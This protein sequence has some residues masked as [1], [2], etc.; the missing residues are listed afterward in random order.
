[1][2]HSRARGLLAASRT[3]LGSRHV[4]RALAWAC[5]CAGALGLAGA[6]GGQAQTQADTADAAASARVEGEYGLRVDNPGDS[7]IVYWLTPGPRAD[8]LVVRRGALRQRYATPAAVTHRV[9]FLAPDPAPLSLQYA[10]TSTTIWPGQPPRPP[11]RV[12]GV[13]SIFVVGDVHGELGNL[14]GVLRNAGV[15][16][17]RLRWVAGRAHLVFLGDFFDRGDDVTR[18][19]WLLYD[20]E[21][22]AAAAGGRVDM[23]LGN[24]EVMVFQSDVRY[25]SPRELSL[26]ARYTVGYARLFDIRRSVLGR[27]LASKPPALMVDGVLFAHGGISTDYLGWSLE[28][29]RDTLGALLRSDLFY[30]TGD[31]LAN[32]PADTARARRIDEFVNGDRSIFWYR[33]YVESDTLADALSLVL[34]HFG[35]RALVVGHTPVKTIHLRYGGWLA[36]TNTAPNAAEL[37][38]ITRRGA[39][40]QGWRYRAAGPPEPLGPIGA[41]LGA[42]R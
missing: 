23:V 32:L 37:L 9:A 12:Q 24:H 1:M 29:L 4:A 21:H 7:I 27:W 3:L 6:A 17:G 31:P 14:L 39:T 16:D 10:G 34:R 5:A 19:L 41:G 18:V 15:V 26:A 42:S 8:T 36:A 25:T 20:L 30:A 2:A 38:L 33:G 28:A 40:L 13:D 35:A 11:L 22:Q